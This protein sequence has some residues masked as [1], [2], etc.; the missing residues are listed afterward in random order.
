MSEGSGRSR[1]GWGLVGGIGV[2]VVALAAYAGVAVV[3]TDWVP[4]GTTVDG[5]VVGGQS[6][7]AAEQRL[8]AHVAAAERKPVTFTAAGRTLQITPASAGL[9][10]GPT[11][12]LNGLTGF[13]LSP[14]ALWKRYTG[15]P[16]RQLKTT[17]DRA[18]L[19]AAIAAASASIKGAPAPGTVKLLGGKVKVT[20]AQP[21]RGVDAASLATSIAAEWPGRT[22]YTATLTPQS[23]VLTDKTVDAFAAGPATAA[24]SGP[25]TLVNGSQQ[26][27]ITP[28]QLSEVL[29]T[30]PSGNSLKLAIIPSAMATLMSTLG[31][32]LA[33]PARNAKVEMNDIVPTKKVI[34]GENGTAVDPVKTGA[35]LI[36]ALQ[37]GRRTVTASVVPQ[38]GVTVD[39]SQ[40][41]T[42]VISEFRSRYPLGAQNA[43]R[44]I[45]IKNG[46]SKLNGT[47]VA[48]GEQFSLLAALSPITKANGYVDAPVLQDG[49]DVLGT[50]GGLSQVSTTMYNATF[51]AGVQ[52]DTHQAHSYWISRYPMGREAT[53]SVPTIDNKW[54]NDT[55]H[56][57]VIE[58]RTES[59]YSV[60]RL[61]GTAVFSVTSTTG[62]QFA[63][64]KAGVQHIT[65]PGCL[66]QPAVPGFKV[67]VTRVVKRGGKV[68]KNESLTTT[69]QP[70]DLVV[71]G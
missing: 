41:S 66:P 49:R 58:A 31:A 5:V 24:L 68:V 19:Q 35:A 23:P 67:T 6:K 57:I 55:G 39:P 36:A 38:K 15:G 64:K 2:L 52:E 4:S 63:I 56:G 37:A 1:K 42:T 8:A 18:K 50:G 7:A 65:T 12:A 22:S 28:A 69:Y 71:C 27:S 32:Q 53:L 45:N 30:V 10:Y 33:T 60:M 25:V 62:P 26:V 21:G 20:H 48:P 40:I 70:A 16:T 11:G 61:Y 43:A 34:A 29:K 9:S 47:Y 59:N 54:T 17:V 3:H 44:T 46:L 14:S 51:F 13:T